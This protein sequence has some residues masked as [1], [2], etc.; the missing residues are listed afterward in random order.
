MIIW[1]TGDDKCESVILIGMVW[2]RFT[3]AD[4]EWNSNRAETVAGVR[5]GRSCWSWSNWQGGYRVARFDDGRWRKGCGPRKGEKFAVV[6]FATQ[7]CRPGWRSKIDPE[8]YRSLSGN[9]RRDDEE[10]PLNSMR[11]IH[12]LTHSNRLCDLVKI[13]QRFSSLVFFDEWRISIAVSNMN[14]MK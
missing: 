4:R 8:T 10:P 1:R 3:L 7:P 12:S 6:S 11:Y 13:V 5:H 14:K 9:N 2:T